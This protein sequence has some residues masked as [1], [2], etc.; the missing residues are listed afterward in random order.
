VR[1]EAIVLVLGCA[2]GG[3]G[4]ETPPASGPE[5]VPLANSPE[6]DAF[7]EPARHDGFVSTFRCTHDSE[8]VAC[9]C[10][11]VN[12]AE[13]ARRGGMDTCHPEPPANEECIATNAACCN[14]VCVLAR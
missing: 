6:H 4:S 7:C 1:V 8:C 14:N 2:L 5:S 3:C 13:V 12:R 10:Q 11:P 9:R